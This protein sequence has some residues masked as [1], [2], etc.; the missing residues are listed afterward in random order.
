MTSTFPNYFSN[1]G[2][3]N[4]YMFIIAENAALGG[5]IFMCNQ[6][7]FEELRFGG[8]LNEGI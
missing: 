5:I 1:R 4:Y 3:L 7:F 8:D 2:S 6:L